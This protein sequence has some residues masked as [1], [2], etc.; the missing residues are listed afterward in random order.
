MLLALL[1]TSSSISATF[2]LI[3]DGKTRVTLL[4]STSPVLTQ[5]PYDLCSSR[6]FSVYTKIH[7]CPLGLRIALR[8]HAV[9]LYIVFA[10]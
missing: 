1:L 4:I 3:S 6:C 5:E 8:V 7:I 10:K 2:L 9:V